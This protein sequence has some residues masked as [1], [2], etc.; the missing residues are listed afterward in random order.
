M[1][2]KDH[3]WSSESI[4]S[5][6]EQDGQTITLRHCRACGRD[7]AFGIDGPR[8][9]AVYIGVFRVEPLSEAVSQRWLEECPKQWLLEDDKARKE[10][11]DSKTPTPRPPT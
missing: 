11:W 9:R 4:R 5:Q 8:W 1:D 6:I 3:S 2:Y 10:R 7:F